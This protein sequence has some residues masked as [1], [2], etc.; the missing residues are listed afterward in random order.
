MILVIFDDPSRIM[1]FVR[2]LMFDVLNS[3][4]VRTLFCLF[5]LFALQYSYSS[6]LVHSAYFTYFIHLTNIYIYIYSPVLRHFV[7][8]ICALLYLL[9][10]LRLF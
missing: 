7:R 10:L 1:S 5:R 4:H 6:Y 8:S 3:L 2:H 9:C